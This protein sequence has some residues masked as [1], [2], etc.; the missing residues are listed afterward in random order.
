ME[1]RNYNSADIAQFTDLMSDLGYPTSI[2]E[3]QLRME[4]I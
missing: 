4:R 2:D 3:M 1:I